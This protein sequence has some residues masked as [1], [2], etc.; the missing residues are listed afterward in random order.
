[1]NYPNLIDVDKV[2]SCS[3]L[4][5]SITQENVH[6][7]VFKEICQIYL[8]LK[9]DLGSDSTEP[10][11]RS[12]IRPLYGHIKTHLMAPLPFNRCQS[13]KLIDEFK[14]FTNNSELTVP[15]YFNKIDEINKNLSDL[16]YDETNPLYEKFEEIVKREDFGNQVG[17]VVPPSY[18]QEVGDF[19]NSRPFVNYENQGKFV[20][21]HP[22]D[23]KKLQCYQ[24]LII[25]GWTRL[26]KQ[27]GFQYIFDA[28][29][30]DKIF[31]ITYD[32]VPNDLT[33][34]ENFVE[35]QNGTSGFQVTIVTE[36]NQDSDK[37]SIIS[38]AIADFDEI[39]PTFSLNELRDRILKDNVD[40]NFDED[41]LAVANFVELADSKGVFL[42]RYSLLNSEKPT[43]HLT[44]SLSDANNPVKRQLLDDIEPGDFLVLRT[45]GGGVDYIEPIADSIM[46]FDASKC[47]ETQKTWKRLL[48]EMI[49]VRGINKVVGD[50]ENIDCKSANIANIRNWVNP[51]NIMPRSKSDF[52]I[53]MSYLNLSERFDEILS[54]SRLINKTH[55]MAGVYLSKT[56]LS[57]IK[58]IS[59]EEL[60]SSTVREFTLDEY[61]SGS[62]TAFQIINVGTE[63]TEIYVSQIGKIL[64]MD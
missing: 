53:L 36:K 37:K 45:E 57:Q 24:T 55:L 9:K 42:N 10:F 54:S 15:S 4:A 46:G 18:I 56:L 8:S 1:M 25:F 19:F 14:G 16:I 26:W 62:M 30:A 13:I 17:L 40:D 28:P 48:K 58:N 44:I 38:T 27:Q 50:L 63:E 47:R 64:E 60:S 39:L 41:D 34:V 2:Y 33:R 5:Q 61:G 20:M 43:K 11:W 29:R 31:L 23:L 6:H 49:N 51:R 35:S 22:R 32:W 12:L 52:Q 59:L 21:V 3:E 7:P